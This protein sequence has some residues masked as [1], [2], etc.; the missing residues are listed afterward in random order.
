MNS[1]DQMKMN[2]SRKNYM[3]NFARRQRNTN[4]RKNL[5]AEVQK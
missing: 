5:N 3:N 2:W 1:E 4:Y